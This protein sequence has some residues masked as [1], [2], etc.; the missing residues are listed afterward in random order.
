M[1]TTDANRSASQG[2]LF[3]ARV[4]IG[5]TTRKK[6]KEISP[7]GGHQPPRICSHS[8]LVVDPVPSSR[9]RR[10]RARGEALAR[11]SVHAVPAAPPAQ[12]GRLVVAD[13]RLCGAALLYWRS[14]ELCRL[15]SPRLS[16]AVLSDGHAPPVLLQLGVSFPGP[17]ERP[18]IVSRAQ[19]PRRVAID[20]ELNGVDAGFL[21]GWHMVDGAGNM[22]W[23]GDKAG[24]G[25]EPSRSICRGCR[26]PEASG[27]RTTAP[28]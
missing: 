11:S 17:Q 22:H 26:P 28:A 6:Q 19:M 25:D 13:E 27:R 23:P 5:C 18:I 8:R 10:S 14:V 9:D 2:D 4:F 16:I 1:V 12:R 21:Q 20:V 3:K 24:S 15:C 7:C